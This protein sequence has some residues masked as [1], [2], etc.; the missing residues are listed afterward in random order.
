MLCGV[1]TNRDGREALT[2]AYVNLKPGTGKTTSTAYTGAAWHAAGHDVLTVDADPGASLLRWADLAGGFPWTV[3]GYPRPTI[4]GNIVTVMER[5]SY[6]RVVIDCPQME[7]HASI[8]RPVLEFA[9]VWIV[10][11]APAGIELDRMIDVARHMDAADYHRDVYGLRVVLLNRTNRPS[12]SSAKRRRD[13][14][15]DA[16]CAEILT[17]RGF[18]VLDQQIPHNDA[19][20]RQCFGALPELAGTPFGDVARALDTLWEA[21][22]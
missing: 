20:Y 18:I 7:D 10:P 19:R 17:E 2:C 6:D 16:E 12:R 1:M 11:L 9:D 3:M 13:I 22:A 8:V 5:S 21:A 4:R 15:P 14:P